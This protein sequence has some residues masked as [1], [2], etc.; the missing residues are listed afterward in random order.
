MANII[1]QK[2]SVA[3]GAV[4]T[5]PE[6]TQGELTL[7]VADGKVFIKTTAN[8]IVDLMGYAVADGGEVTAP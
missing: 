5:T 3:P 6:I 2:R 1:Q 8:E 7:Q 4:P